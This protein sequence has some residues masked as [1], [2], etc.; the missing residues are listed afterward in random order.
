MMTGLKG[1][2]VVTGANGG[3]GS[4]TVS[5][6]VSS[7][8]L[9]ASYHGVY[10]VRNAASSHTLDAALVDRVSHRRPLRDNRA[11]LHSHEKISL[12]LSRLSNVRE[13]AAQI[14]ERVAAGTIP[15]IHAIILN[16]GYEEF[17]KQTWT[18]DGFDM[19][20][21]TNYLGH[22]LLTVLL[23]QSMDRDVGRVLWISSWSHK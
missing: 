9:S 7:P 2:I 19:T 8:Q 12:D 1:T 13:V 15:H 21:A 6:I 5:H 18:V 22:W 20:F 11:S 23:L 4:A 3:L 14:N 16:A 17:E 10:T